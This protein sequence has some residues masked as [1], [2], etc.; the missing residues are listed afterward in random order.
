MAEATQTQ[1][2]AAMFLVCPFPVPIPSKM[3]FSKNG[4]KTVQT[5]D[6]AD[7]TNKKNIAKRP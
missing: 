5:L 2:K 7:A 6:I 4:I 3:A 1:I